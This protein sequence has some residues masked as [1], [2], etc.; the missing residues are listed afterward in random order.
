VRTAALKRAQAKL[1]VTD[2]T[3]G[4]VRR[5]RSAAISS[6]GAALIRPAHREDYVLM[7]ASSHTVKEYEESGGT[8]TCRLVAP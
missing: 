5:R 6:A 1:K 4:G 8:T 7:G 3:P 2:T